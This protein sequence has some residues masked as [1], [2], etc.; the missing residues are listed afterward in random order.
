MGCDRTFAQEK[1]GEEVLG[2]FVGIWKLD[3]EASPSKWA[4]EGKTISGHENAIWALKKRVILIRAVDKRDNRRSLFISTFDPDRNVY[5][6]WGFDSQSLMGA[7]WELSWDAD[8]KA[9]VGHATDLPTGWTSIGRNQFPDADTNNVTVW[10]KDDV[11]EVLLNHK[12][13]KKRLP[14]KE[15]PE[16]AA[17]WS[18]KEEPDN[19]PVELKVLDRMV[20]TWDD[21]SIQKP[22]AWTPDGGRVTARITRHW[23]L[24]GRLIM[25]TSTLSD[26]T[27]NIA[28][29]GFDP[30]SKDYRS[31]WFNSEGHR[32]TATGS[33]NEKS[34]T[35]SYVS[36]L[37]DGKTMRTS[38]RFANRNQEVWEFKVTDADGK[39]YFD[40]DS[41]ATRQAA[42]AD[43]QP[44]SD[45]DQP[46]PTDE[47]RLRGTWG[48]T[49]YVQDGQGEGEALIAPED[50][51]IQF[52]FKGNKF[53]LL[54]S[55]NA[56][57]SPKGSYK[58][59]SSG[60]EKTI[61]LIFPSGSNGAKKQT[62]SGIYKFDGETLKITFAPDGARSP[63]D[64]RSTAGS[65]LTA[66]VFKR[67]KE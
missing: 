44:N 15:G 63:N 37:D 28:I 12:F 9:T 1:N 46:T 38:L 43:K 8:S 59:G 36:K 26:G 40:M 18:M 7:E 49:Q 20:G 23:I 51:A 39:V 17:A 4:P 55:G 66:I 19:L 41:I 31:W 2:R 60:K 33:W 3:G 45:A 24:D 21:V 52:V 13:T 50:S 16:I 47:S 27:E 53:L 48:A 58:L 32:N 5:P 57:E 35:I 61:D 22:A 65:K 30:Q 42:G 64:F 29:F 10:M 6:M 14:D 62:M 34:Q 11:G 25:D 67:I 56:D 54:A